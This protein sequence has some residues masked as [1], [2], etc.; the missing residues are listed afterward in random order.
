[1]KKDVVKR[2]F[3]TFVFGGCFGV[4]SQIFVVL[5]RA[6][7]GEESTW[8]MPLMLVTLGF[9][10][11]ILYII[12][13][14]QKFEDVGV[15]GAIMPFSG[16]VSAVATAFMQEDARGGTARGVGAGFL[17]FLYVL[18]VGGLL[19]ALMGSVIA[20]GMMAL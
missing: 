15:M 6:I 20:I 14:Y 9:V 18:G 2:L 7:L 4:L 19:S 8:V 12:G 16:L 3:A 11:A 5:W 1:M 17:F 10:G 13:I